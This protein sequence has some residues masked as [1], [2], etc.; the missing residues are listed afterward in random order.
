MRELKFK[1]WLIKENRLV[2]ID[3]IHWNKGYGNALQIHVYNPEFK[4]YKH[5]V[6]NPKSGVQ[7]FFSYINHSLEVHKKAN[8]GDD[9]VLLQN[10]GLKDKNGIEIYEG[11]IV[12]THRET[13]FKNVV[14][15][16]FEYLD[17]D[18][19]G[20]VVIIPSKGACPR[21]P[22]YECNL[23]GEKGKLNYYYNVASYRSI[24]I[25]NIFENPNL[26][27]S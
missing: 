25:G 15:G 16:E 12:S 26:I 4:P 9:F 17:Q 19:I 18:L 24:V 2:F 23:S 7:P 11:D 6:E 3:T 22:N 5:I 8:N 20:E 21:K 27:K 10:T 14:S 1:A 13:S